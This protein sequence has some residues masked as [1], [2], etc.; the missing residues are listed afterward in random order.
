MVLHHSEKY[1]QL[2]IEELLG[3]LEQ[4]ALSDPSPDVRS[5]AAMVLAA[6]GNREFPRTVP[7]FERMA[8]AYRLSSDNTVKAMIA[9]NMARIAE[10]QE[11][12][13]FLEQLATTPT[14]KLPYNYAAGEAVHYLSGMGQEGSDVLRSLDAAGA[15]RDA[16]AKRALAYLAGRSYRAR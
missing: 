16:E 2:S 3:G 9:M 5:A 10:R 13:A 4:L 8:R 12:L 6:P 14:D 11:A 1:P 15:V 7:V